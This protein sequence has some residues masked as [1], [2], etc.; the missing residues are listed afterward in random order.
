M[1]DIADLFLTELAIDVAKANMDKGFWNKRQNLK[2]CLFNRDAQLELIEALA[3]IM[4]E[5]AEAIE[6]VRKNL[7][8]SE[9]MDQHLPH[10]TNLETELADIMI[11][12]LDLA[13]G[14]NIDIGQVVWEKLEYNSTRPY[15]H[16]KTC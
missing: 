2:E 7:N 12:C 14:L 10:R 5:A 9:D 4:T 1:T 15:L 6:S 3:L 13:G 11:R 16:G 8:W